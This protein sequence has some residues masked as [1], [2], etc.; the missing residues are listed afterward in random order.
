MQWFSLIKVK[1]ES[2]NVTV[3]E[4]TPKQIQLGTPDQALNYLDNKE[5]GSDF[6]MSD[7]LRKTTG[8]EQIEK[9]TEQQKVELLALEKVATIQEQAYE[10]G[11]KLGQ[12]EGFKSASDKKISELEHGIQ[13][14]AETLQALSVI[15][16]ELAVQSEAHIV[17]LVYQIAEK[18]AFDHIDQHP[19]VVLSVIKNA[20]EI[21]QVE[22]DITVLV[23]A[24]QVEFL[25]KMKMMTGRDFDFLKNVK[26]QQ[27]ERVRS[28]G[29]IVE[30]NYGIIDSRVEERTEK[31]WEEFKEMLPKVKSSLAG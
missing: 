19:E 23:S 20:I 13:Q 3:M 7:V 11:F 18:I 16:S 2:D 14:L 1:S 5:K 9:Q 12:E 15:K 6:V 10:E 26:F 29:C 22:Q 27:S 28:G 24:E 30:T 17:K 8:I 21:A 25:E 31:L 4:Y